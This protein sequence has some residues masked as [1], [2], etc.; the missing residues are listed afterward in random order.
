MVLF[1]ALGA[2]QIVVVVYISLAAVYTT[3]NLL[4]IL[5]YALK[6]DLSNDGA[7]VPHLSEFPSRTETL[8]LSEKLF[9]S[10]AF[11]QSMH[12]SRIIPYFYR[13]T[14][15]L[16]ADDITIT[17]LVTSN[18]FEVFK[19]LVES[20]KGP[21]SV[22]I[23][24]KDTT[25]EIQ[26]FLDSLHQLYISTPLM[27]AYVDVHLMIDHF[28]RQFNTWRNIARLFAR[29]DYVMMLDVD[30]AVCTDFRSSVRKSRLIMDKLKSG[31]AALV[32]PAFEYV[33]Q[34]DGVDQGKFARTKKALVSLVQQ[35][36]VDVFHRSWAPGHNSTDYK[37]FY[38]ARPGEVYKV[39]KYQSAYEPYII[40]KKEGPPWCDERFVGYGGNKAACLFE[41][42]LSGVAFY[43]L[44]DHFLIHQSHQYEEEARKT[45]RKYNKKIYS[46]FKEE[47]CLRYLKRFYDQGILDTTQGYNV[48]EECKK[49][50]GF[51][52]IAAQVCK[53]LPV[54]IIV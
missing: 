52:R 51:S 14:A 43:V 28:D 21:I 37:R 45:E 29:T 2:L 15:N 9:L 44:A 8:E 39:T 5:D 27:S 35:G 33:K 42:Y 32:V 34:S 6:L 40:F 23:H 36:L 7:R 25:E 18:R 22:A 30:F 11:A 17:T 1:R 53:V 47:A 49:I 4:G 3:C 26:A 38:A 54:L 10:K 20:Y 12:P 19:K 16:E 48:Q 46:D 41:M 13:A 50:K 24:I 31:N